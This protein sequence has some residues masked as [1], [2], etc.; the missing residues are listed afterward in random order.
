MKKWLTLMVLGAVVATAGLSSRVA[1]QP[2]GEPTEAEV[3]AKVDERLREVMHTLLS[4]QDANA[5]TAAL[6]R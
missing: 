6:H 2:E 5:R 1:A 4:K 3:H